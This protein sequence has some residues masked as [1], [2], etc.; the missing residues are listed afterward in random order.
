MLA[1]ELSD[2]LYMIFV[3]ADYYGIKLE[4]PFQRTI[5]GHLSR[6]IK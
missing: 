2:L 6:F 5:N 1:T 3:L 4:K